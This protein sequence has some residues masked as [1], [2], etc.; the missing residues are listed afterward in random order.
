MQ[1]WEGLNDTTDYVNNFGGAYFNSLS[2]GAT[3]ELNGNIAGVTASV[4][5]AG[6][7]AFNAYGNVAIN[8]TGATTSRGLAVDINSQSSTIEVGDATHWGCLEMGTPGGLVYW[9]ATTTSPFF[10]ATTTKPSFACE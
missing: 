9:Y 3:A 1:Q 5:N 10:I 2:G 8:T 4:A 6:S 7:D